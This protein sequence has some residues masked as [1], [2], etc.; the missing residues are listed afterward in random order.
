QQIG[1]WTLGITAIIGTATTLAMLTSARTR[2][3][4][5][6]IIWAGCI[7][8]FTFFLTGFFVHA[9]QRYVFF[10]MVLLSGVGIAGIYYLL[11]DFFLPLAVLAPLMIGA[12][13]LYFGVSDYQNSNTFL[14]QKS[15]AI[16]NAVLIEALQ[17][18]QTDSTN[19]DGCDIWSAING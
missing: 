17:L 4:Y 15:D 10:P 16:S 3:Q 8:I 11:A 7:G 18:I 9:E 13:G 2:G 19:A 12:A 14:S 6:G 1:G 5:T